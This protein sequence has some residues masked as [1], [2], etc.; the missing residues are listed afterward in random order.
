MA[1]ETPLISRKPLTSVSDSGE[2]NRALNLFLDDF[3][4][5]RKVARFAVL[6]FAPMVEY[7]PT[8][9]EARRR[10]EKL[11]PSQ[12][13]ALVDRETGITKCRR[14]YCDFVM[15]RLRRDGTAPAEFV[16]TGP[17]QL[18]MKKRQRREE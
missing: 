7:Y 12:R 2:E 16:R 11:E 6:R 17:L 1:D 5:P 8:E 18:S 9:E 13:V 4:Q 15:E 3:K 10:L 14:P